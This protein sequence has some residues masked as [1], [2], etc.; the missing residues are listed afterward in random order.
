M[1]MSEQYGLWYS[2][3]WVHES[4]HAAPRAWRG[5]KEEAEATADKMAADGSSRPTVKPLSEPWRVMPFGDDPE[6]GRRFCG[7]FPGGGT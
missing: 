1:T 6:G 7:R 5:T 2:N 4:I 3:G